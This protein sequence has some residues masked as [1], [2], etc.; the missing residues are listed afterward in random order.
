MNEITARTSVADDA[1]EQRAAAQN[2][3]KELFE[4]RGQFIPINAPTWEK[5]RE[6]A[7][8]YLAAL[9]AFGL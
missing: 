7:L 4:M 3:Q 5:F 1:A 2:R 6:R 8:E 9:E